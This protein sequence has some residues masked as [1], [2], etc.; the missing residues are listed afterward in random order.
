MIQIRKSKDRGHFDHGWLLPQSKGIHPSYEQKAFDAG[1]R[2]NRLRLV[3]SQDGREESLTIHQDADIH[4]A[5]LVSG[6]E[7]EYTLNSHRHAWLQVL[8]GTVAL[9]GQ[10]LRQSDGA[11][12]G[13][14]RQLRIVATRT[15]EV[16]LFDLA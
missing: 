13:N 10:A 8:R 2:T 7:V 3:A 4:L 1:K 5:T 6:K 9:N 12:I 14:E 15:A 16:M 11:A